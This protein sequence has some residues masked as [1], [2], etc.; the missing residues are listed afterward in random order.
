MYCSAL[1]DRSPS[2]L[3]CGRDLVISKSTRFL[4]SFIS[5]SE[6]LRQAYITPTFLHQTVTET[7]RSLHSMVHATWSITQ[8]MSIVHCF[9]FI[10]DIELFFLW[11]SINFMFH[12]NGLI[13][14]SRNHRERHISFFIKSFTRI[15]T[16]VS[17]RSKNKKLSS[18][19]K[20]LVQFQ[21]REIIV[22]FKFSLS[23][24]FRSSYKDTSYRS[25][26]VIVPDT[27][28]AIPIVVYLVSLTNGR[29]YCSCLTPRNRNYTQT[30][31]S[32]SSLLLHSRS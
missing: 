11:F 1:P 5:H 28:P 29:P 14:T 25:I 10:A 23:T 6:F 12:F 20:A 4:Q 7:G 9:G 22:L 30:V 8:S 2:V 32:L 3:S 18:R 13:F 26:F 21:T 15:N 19:L 16:L 17:H 24:P 31:T 27:L